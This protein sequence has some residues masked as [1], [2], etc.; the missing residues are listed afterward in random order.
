MTTRHANI[1][2]KNIVYIDND[3]ALR[4]LCQDW[5]D[6][7]WLAVD[8]EFIRE[9]TYYPQVCLIQIATESDIALIDPLT[10]GALNPL[11]DLLAQPHIVKVVHAGHQ[12]LEIFYHLGGRVPAPVFDTQLAAPLLGLPP[13]CAYAALVSSLLGVH[14]EKQHARADWRKRPLPQSWLAYAADDV[15]YL[16]HVYLLM[17]DDLAQRQRLS[18]LDD[19]FD[20]LVS[21]SRY[22]NPP[23]EAWRRIK[24]GHR[25]RGAS[26]SLFRA[27]AQWREEQASSTDI[28]RQWLLRDETLIDIARQKPGDE[29][30]LADIRGI[31]PEFM[32]RYGAQILTVLADARR[33]PAPATAAT[34]AS[35]SR[36]EPGQEALVDALLAVV[37]LCAARNKLHPSLLASRK[38]IESFVRGDRDVGFLSGWRRPLVGDTI[39]AIMAGE[40]VLEIDDGQLVLVEAGTAKHVRR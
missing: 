40:Q 30:T 1:K 25:L 8:T 27:L 38:D 6:Q 14:L 36:L 20:R 23:A 10:I 24:G 17:R 28:P 26:Q 33:Q 21:S 2:D 29:D 15:R 32:K 13:Q 34:A 9:R 37:S 31:N 22:D 16:G 12:D 18:W 11:L 35:R 3:E 4:T 5:Q 7:E 39:L 19:D